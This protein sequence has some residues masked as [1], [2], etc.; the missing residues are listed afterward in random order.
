MEI[1]NLHSRLRKDWACL[2][3]AVAFVAV[4]SRS[5][6]Q[7]ASTT[8]GQGSASPAQLTEWD[9]VMGGAFHFLHELFPD[10]KPESKSI[11]QNIGDWRSS[12]RGIQWFTIHVCDP[13][14][15][16]RNEELQRDFFSRYDI[17]CSV[18]R[19][20][21]T[22]RIGRSQF[23]SVPG[24]ISIFRPDLD[25]RWSELAAL[26]VAHPKWSEFQQEEAMSAAG[27][28][29][30]AGGNNGMVVLLHEVWPKLEMFFGKLKLDSMKYSPPFQPESGEMVPPSW[31]I[32]AHP[33]EQYL[34][35]PSTEYLFM[36]N[37]FD[38]SF[39][40][41]QQVLPAPSEKP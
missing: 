17:Q 13:D 12:P 7:T 14:F 40:S 25:K 6:G 29:Y 2:F 37:A 41:E 20:E 31:N 30:G 24:N 22:F 1:R 16:S 8:G 4:S 38:G 28:K 34:A 27:V 3:L 33:V 10:I 32:R 26:F 19:I 5:Y 9:D 23:G 21:A 36:F 39:E 35:K 18:L 15:A 11:I